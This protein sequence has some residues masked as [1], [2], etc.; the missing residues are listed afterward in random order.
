MPPVRVAAVVAARNEGGRVG[1][2]VRGI[3]AIPGV[4]E[5]VVADG[6]SGDRTAEESREAGARVLVGPRRHG[7][8]GAL[9]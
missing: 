6:S 1:E 9:E 7:K 5:V 3:R 2:T 4:D 8:G